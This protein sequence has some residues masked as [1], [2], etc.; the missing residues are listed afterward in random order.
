LKE[1]RLNFEEDSVPKP[2]RFAVNEVENA[3]FG[4]KLKFD[5]KFDNHDFRVNLIHRRLFKNHYR[6][7][8]F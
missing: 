5:A 1:E 6:K 4:L 2:M 7:A 3:S 8:V